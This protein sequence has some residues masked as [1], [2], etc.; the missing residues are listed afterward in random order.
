LTAEIKSA[1][2]DALSGSAGYPRVERAPVIF[3][4]SAGLGGRD[5][6]PGD[7]VELVEQMRKKMS[8]RFFVL[9]VKHD[10]ALTPSRDPDVR[11][12]GAFS[13]RGHSVGGYG[14]ITTN[15]VIATIVGDLFGLQVQA[16]PKYGSEKKGLPTTY[17]LTVANRHIR[18]HSELKYVDFVSL[19]NSSAFHLGNPLDGLSP[20]GTLFLHH[21]S[22]D[23]TQVWASIPPFA[24]EIIRKNHI[25]VLSLDAVKIAEEVAT[26]R[27]LAQ[28]MQGIVL[29]GIFLRVVPFVKQKRLSDEALFAAVEKSLR[30]FFGNRGKQVVQDNLRAVSRGY[31]EVFEVPRTIMKVAA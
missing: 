12:P 25:R 5:I 19:N 24:Q 18:A 10:L 4:G 31:R 20:K 1:F 2:A 8:P 7:F 6:R 13:M 30:K 16:Y 28:R 17:F 21:E 26:R 11:P 9:G 14:S 22:K 27:E 3:S 29:L 15:K 23:P